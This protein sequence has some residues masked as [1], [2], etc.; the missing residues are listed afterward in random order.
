MST[1]FFGATA[2][3]NNVTAAQTDMN[4]YECVQHR[5]LLEQHERGTLS[6]HLTQVCLGRVAVSRSEQ[7]VGFQVILSFL[8]KEPWRSPAGKQ[9]LSALLEGKG[10]KK[11]IWDCGALWGAFSKFIVT[12]L[13]T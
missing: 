5:S 9:N 2:R 11:T 4:G 12:I 1:G 8:A 3:K 6:S 10:G 7:T 13:L